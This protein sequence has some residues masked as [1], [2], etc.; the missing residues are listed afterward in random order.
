MRPQRP[1]Q[2]GVG[3]AGCVAEREAGRCVVLLQCL[4]EFE[5]AAGVFR[6]FLEA[7]LVHR[8]DAVVHQ[9][10]G[11]RDRQADPL[12][13]RLAVGFGRRRPAAVLLAEVIGDRGHIE[14]L[15]GEQVR[16][17]GETPHHVEAGAGVCRDRCFRLHVF[18]R[19]VRDGNGNAGCLLEGVHHRHE[20][21][22]FGFDEAAPAQHVDLRAILR[23]KRR[24][25]RPGGRVV[26]QLIGTYSRNRSS[27]S[28]AFQQRAAVHF[29]LFVHDFLPWTALIRKLR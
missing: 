12:A 28:R 20:S 27:R 5:E 8:A 16:Q 9:T 26:Q 1:V 17:R 22:V 19:L 21:L 4:H 23:L 15:L 11:G 6:E 29:K 14:T 3:V 18:E 24:C 7:R 10:A 13:F 25:L 2:P